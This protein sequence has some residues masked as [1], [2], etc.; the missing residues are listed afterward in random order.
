LQ[1]I[2]HKT[3]A[4]GSTLSRFAYA[5]DVVGNI[6]TWTQQ[7]GSVERAYDLRYDAV[8]QLVSAVYR[9]TDPTPTVLKRYGY[10]YDPAGNR[11]SEQADDSP[12]AS[13]FDDMNRLTSQ[14][15]GGT[16]SFKGTLSEPASVWVQG[17]PGD[18]ASDNSFQ[19]LASVVPGTNSVAVVATDPSGNTR[20]N[21]YQ[22][23]V[24]AGAKTLGYDGNGSLT[25]SG[26]RTYE[27]DGNNRLVKVLDNG[28]EVA[29]FTYD[30]LGRRAQKVAGGVTRT[31]VY[32]GEDILEERLSS[33]GTIRYVHGPGIDQPLAS[34]DGAGAV[35]Y[36]LADHLGSIVQTTNAAAQLT[37]TR[38]YDPYGNILAGQA[39]SGYAFTGREWDSETGLHYYRARYYD[40]KV[41]RFLS[42]DP[43]GFTAGINFYSYALNTPSRF[44]DPYGLEVWPEHVRPPYPPEPSGP[45]TWNPWDIK[46]QVDHWGNPYDNRDP[47]NRIRHCIASCRVTRES[48]G[49]RFTAWVGGSMQDP[50]SWTDPDSSGDR[51]ANERGRCLANQ[52]PER[53]C[54]T[55]CIDEFLNGNLY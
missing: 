53:S 20:T 38:Q 45:S 47:M 25:T 7:Y 11:T 5:Y 23:S 41:G 18:V 32:D 27:W 39:T 37:L 29:R 52:D 30:G 46:D 42:E 50:P 55:I 31:F 16:L 36:F 24:S 17:R 40:A 2:H 49:G 54:E 1:E 48:P 6:K 22:V 4:T 15:G 35:G 26:T 10:A 13:V 8:D 12:T 14:D 44:T 51:D 21:T 43:I 33:G 19:G 34:V 9:T 3:N 28:S